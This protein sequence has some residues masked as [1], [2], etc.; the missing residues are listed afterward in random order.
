MVNLILYLA[1]G[2]KWP[3]RGTESLAPLTLGTIS[4][5]PVSENQTGSNVSSAVPASAKPLDLQPDSII[6]EG[7]NVWYSADSGNCPDKTE[8]FSKTDEAV[9]LGNT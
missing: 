8:E 9:P 6:L 5:V 2:G 3:G 7:F 1:F 4:E